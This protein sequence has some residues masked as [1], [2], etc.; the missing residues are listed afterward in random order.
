MKS[1]FRKKFD[2]KLI[3]TSLSLASFKEGG[4]GSSRCFDQKVIWKTLRLERKLVHIVFVVLCLSPH[5]INC[6]DM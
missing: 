1:A 4:N 6:A 5:I 2:V 3:L